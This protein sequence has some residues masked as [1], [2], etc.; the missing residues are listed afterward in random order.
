MTRQIDFLTDSSE[1]EYEKIAGEYYYK[2]W[3]S[4]ELPPS[5]KTKIYNIIT[6]A[7][8]SGFEK[9]LVACAKNEKLNKPNDCIYEIYYR[10]W[11]AL[12]DAS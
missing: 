9:E 10:V 1:S 11:L 12:R 6:R 5:K 4:E 8:G 3:G 2:G 7:R